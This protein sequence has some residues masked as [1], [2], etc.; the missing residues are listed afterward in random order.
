MVVQ[1]RESDESPVK[2][3]ADLTK[4]DLALG[5]RA[6]KRIDIMCLVGLVIVLVLGV[7]VF[8]AVP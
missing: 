5:M 8:V 6:S 3:P 7:G 2:P 4:Q 1:K